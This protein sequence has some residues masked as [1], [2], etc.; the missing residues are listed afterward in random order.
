MVFSCEEEG[1][2]VVGLLQ[3]DDA[4]GKNAGVN[5]KNKL[6]SS[7]NGSKHNIITSTFLTPL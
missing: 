4:G 3:E 6:F 5:V 1:G 2:A 7:G